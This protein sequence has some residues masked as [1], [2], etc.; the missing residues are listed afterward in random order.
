MKKWCED[1][2]INVVPRAIN[3]QNCPE[4]RPT[5]RFRAVMKA[6][7]RKMGGESKSVQQFK[8]KWIKAYNTRGEKLVQA[9][10]V[11]IKTKVRKFGR[12]GEILNFKSKDVKFCI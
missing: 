11:G 10:M 7:C 2:N 1:N 3:P 4:L 5:E 9:L 12:E 6:D 8:R